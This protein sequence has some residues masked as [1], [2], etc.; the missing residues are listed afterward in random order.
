MGT[1]SQTAA[2]L[3]IPTAEAQERFVPLME[4]V[5]RVASLFFRS[6]KCSSRR[7][8]LTQEALALGWKYHLSALQRGK[9]LRDYVGAFA[10]FCCRHA[11]RGT[12]LAGGQARRDVLDPA[13][14]R[15]F[16]RGLTP[17]AVD[18]ANTV[19]VLLDQLQDRGSHD[20][21]TRAVIRLAFTAFL[22]SLSERTRAVADLLAAGHST[23]KTSALSGLTPGRISQIRREL[24]VA[25]EAF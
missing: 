11:F 12:R 25:W 18:P 16:E 4:A 24:L 20:P 6:I 9:D 7:D 15:E 3:P 23:K 17:L 2:S 1:L 22:N 21:A 5:Q 13:N 8:D 14:H 10:T 19:S